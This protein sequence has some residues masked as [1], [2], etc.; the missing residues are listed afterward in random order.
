MLLPLE[1]MLAQSPLWHVFIHQKPLVA[2]NTVPQERNQMPVPN[3]GEDSNFGLELVQSLCAHHPRLHSFHSNLS[4]I[5]QFTLVNDPKSSSAQHIIFTEILAWN[6]IIPIHIIPIGFKQL[7]PNLGPFNPAKSLVPS[8]DIA[9]IGNKQHNS[10]EYQNGYHNPSNHSCRTRR[11][12]SRFRRA[13]IR[14]PTVRSRGPT[15]ARYIPTEKR[16]AIVI[17]SH[18]NSKCRDRTG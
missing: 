4:P 9:F 7:L 17:K 10:R 11:A 5:L 18:A 2:I 3:F 15:S 14:I 12:L 1:Q 16:I 8:L 6:S 13:S